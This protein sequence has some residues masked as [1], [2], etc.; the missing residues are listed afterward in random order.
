MA[1]GASEFM[2][3]NRLTG[4][5]G[6]FQ[7]LV[8]SKITENHAFDLMESVFTYFPMYISL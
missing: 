2:K 5:L 8:A 4:V 7:K 6:I 1:R 3:E